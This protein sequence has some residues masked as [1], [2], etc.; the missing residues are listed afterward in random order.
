MR[1]FFLLRCLIK[2]RGVLS[3][4]KM[5]QGL[6][7]MQMLLVDLA[8]TFSK[9]DIYFGVFSLMDKGTW[10]KRSGYY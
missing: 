1:M 8:W 5:L 4:K 10:H 7:Y 3:N 2:Q 6:L 9:Q